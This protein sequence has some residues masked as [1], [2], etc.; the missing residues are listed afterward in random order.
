MGYSVRTGQGELR[1]I[2][3]TWERHEPKT[4]E[5]CPLPITSRSAPYRFAVSGTIDAI[6]PLSTHMG[7]FAN[8]SQDCTRE[9]SSDSDLSGDTAWTIVREHSRSSASRA[10]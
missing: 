7:T 1:I 5:A 9:K 6:S 8:A 4:S 3:C 10:A 2:E